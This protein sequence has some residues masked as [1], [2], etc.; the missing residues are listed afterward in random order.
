MVTPIRF[1]QSE[2]SNRHLKTERR[3]DVPKSTILLQGTVKSYA[4]AVH[5][6]QTR[7]DMK[8]FL[9]PVIGGILLAVP[10]FL[11]L[12]IYLGFMTIGPA[13]VSSLI[14]G[15]LF[16]LLVLRAGLRAIWIPI[17]SAT[18]GLLGIGFVQLISGS[19]LFGI[20]YYIL[21]PVLTACTVTFF[22]SLLLLLVPTLRTRL[23]GEDKTNALE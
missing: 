13:V 7:A 23:F 14:I 15:S 3:R 11:L 12:T 1:L 8:L 22:L 19:G 17:G 2:Q 9:F 6:T 10:V 18:L 21:V 16:G 5:Q 4:F 20:I